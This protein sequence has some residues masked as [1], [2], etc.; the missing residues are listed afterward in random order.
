MRQN[1][2]AENPEFANIPQNDVGTYLLNS[3]ER[4]QLRNKIITE[5]LQEGSFS[6]I[7]KNRKE[8]YNGN[9]K[10]DKRLDIVIG[11]PAAGKSS[12]IVNTL[13]EF[14]QSA[15]IDSDII[16]TLLPEF[17]DGWGAMLVH[18]ESSYINSRLLEEKMNTDSNI[19]LPIVG[20]K[21]NSVDKYIIIA[22]KYGYDVN[23]HLNELSNEKAIGRM[24]KRYF[25]TGRFINPSFAIEYGNKPTDVYE[26][27][28]QRGDIS[29]YSRWNNDV[30]KGKDQSSLK[31]ATTTDYTAHTMKRAERA[32]D[33]YLDDWLKR[34][35]ET[36]K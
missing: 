26:Q 28:K 31:L 13:S 33:K 32:V 24:L 11:L 22:N 7:D 10:K 34:L 36:T 1:F 5:R 30:K 25:D 4:V 23:V 17:N 16:K 14:Y 2:I 12:A 19:V 21:I 15:V 20:S 35:N 9:V 8:V 6:G 29:G 18:E 27:I 3:D